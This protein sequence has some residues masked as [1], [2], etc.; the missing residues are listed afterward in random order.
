MLKYAFVLIFPNCFFALILSINDTVLAGSLLFPKEKYFCLYYLFVFV[1]KIRQFHD[2]SGISPALHNALS[3]LLSCC[4]QHFFPVRV[5]TS[6]I[7]LLLVVTLLQDTNRRG[8][9]LS[10]VSSIYTKDFFCEGQK[11]LVNLENK[12]NLPNYQ[13]LK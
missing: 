13:L 5:L 11:N 10:H 12:E 8:D 9:N 4:S 2:P 3:T 6:F 7:H 1:E